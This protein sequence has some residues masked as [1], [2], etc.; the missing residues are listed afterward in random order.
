MARRRPRAPQR[1]EMP[2]QANRRPK[3]AAVIA[4]AHEFYEITH[5]LEQDAITQRRCPSRTQG[6]E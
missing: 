5:R 4:H 1:S 3:K 2:P 6:W